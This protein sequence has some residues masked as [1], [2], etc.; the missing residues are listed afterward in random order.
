MAAKKFELFMGCLGNGVTVCNKAVMEHGDYKMVAHISPEGSVK[1]YV[2]DGYTPPEAR[3]KIEA[4]AARLR[5]EHEKWWNGLSEAERY[6]RTLDAMSP[7]ELVEH[8][9]RKRGEKA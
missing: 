9:K 1:W 8:I 5:T 3:E 2:P 4:E 6:A 7:A